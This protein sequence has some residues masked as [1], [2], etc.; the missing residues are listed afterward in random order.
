MV[1]F[2][3]LWEKEKAHARVDK[4]KYISLQ[5]YDSEVLLDLLISWKNEYLSK[6]K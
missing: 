2:A 6:K 4:E 3:I 1:Q 5:A